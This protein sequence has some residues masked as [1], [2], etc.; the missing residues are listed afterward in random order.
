MTENF[1]FELMRF[2]NTSKKSG[3]HR[4]LNLWS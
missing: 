4:H 3:C 1:S 2:L